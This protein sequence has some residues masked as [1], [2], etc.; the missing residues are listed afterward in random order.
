MRQT[1]QVII[2][3]NDLNMRKGKMVAQG[4]HASMAVI[5]KNLNILYN[6]GETIGQFNLREEF[7]DWLNNSYTKICLQCDSEKEL[8]ELYNKAKE[9]NILCSLIKDNGKTEF[10]GIPTYTSVAIGPDYSEKI[11]Q[12]TKHLKLF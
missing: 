6:N 2:L 3:R 1:K 9:M 7:I 12:I 4:S 8:L 11:D 5:T 10:N